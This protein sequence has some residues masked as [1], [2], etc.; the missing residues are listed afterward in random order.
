MDY[1]RSAFESAKEQATK[2][3]AEAKSAEE[4][5]RKLQVLQGDL[6]N[7]DL[8]KLDMSAVKS[9]MTTMTDSMNKAF[10]TYTTGG[11]VSEQDRAEYGLTDDFIAH[12][13]GFSYMLFMDFPVG[14]LEITR[15]LTPRSMPKTMKLAPWQ[16]KHAMLL[17]QS[18][19]EFN[20]LRYVL[21]PK[22]MAEERFWEIYFTLCKEKLPPQAQDFVMLAA[23]AVTVHTTTVTSTRR[24]EEEEAYGDLGA[25]TL[26]Q[27]DD[28]VEAE[29]ISPPPAVLSDASGSAYNSETSSPE[30]AGQLGYLPPSPPASPAAFF[31]R[32]GNIAQPSAESKPAAPAA[33]ATGVQRSRTSADAGIAAAE[34]T[35]EAGADGSFHD[36]EELV[37]DVDGDEEDDFDAYVQGML[38]GDGGDSDDG[39]DE[40]DGGD[41]ED[42]FDAYMA[43]LAKESGDG[44]GG[45]DDADDVSLLS[46]DIDLAELE[47]DK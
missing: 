17:V 21:C 41:D 3:A 22:K 32:E 16:E 43:E 4:A 15:D 2:A 18:I 29:A 28:E 37:D 20:D 36:S 44:S 24:E 33:T 5:S 38:G 8:K 10:A 35:E 26:A 14:H 12:V 9:S 45:D 27:D 11:G 34:E 23:Q 42:D 40:G 19:P 47:E 7:L 25:F 1:F 31:L 13:K 6:K 46:D 39:D 30:K